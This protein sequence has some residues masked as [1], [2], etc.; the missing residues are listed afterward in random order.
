MNYERHELSAIF[1][2]TTAPELNQLA[3]DIGKNGL[4]HPILLW[5]G[6]VL[7]GWHRLQACRAAG[8]APRFETFEGDDKAALTRV[9]SENARRRHLTEA[10]RVELSKLATGWYANAAT[11]GQPAKSI[12]TQGPN[13]VKV[14]TL[15][16]LAE[17]STKTVVRHTTLERNAPELLA[18]VNAG[19]LSLKT[20][21]SVATKAPSE[22]LHKPDAESVKAFAAALA[23]GPAHKAA[24][25]R[26][27]VDRLDELLRELRHHQADETVN[28]ALAYSQFVIRA[29]FSGGEDVKSSPDS[30]PAGQAVSPS[31][32]GDGRG[33]CKKSWLFAFGNGA[34]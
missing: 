26:R 34:Q 30:W 4:H 12:G 15:A 17:V 3:A 13:T 6:K 29:A 22:L 19:K 24:E 11:V 33:E 2:D 31:L 21:A 32:A 16:E 5:Q 9:F 1:G 23:A 8:V 20:A 10:K 27:V 14:E 28:E 25:L 18:L 7:D